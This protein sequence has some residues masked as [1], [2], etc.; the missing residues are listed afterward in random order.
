MKIERTIACYSNDSEELISE[1]NIDSIGLEILK[2][3]F[4]PTAEDPLMYEV[5][6]IEEREATELLHH[7]DIAFDFSNYAYFV[8]CCQLPPYSFDK[9]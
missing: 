7:I 1:V 4:R 2:R 9:K 5:Y 3:I 6:L 8:E